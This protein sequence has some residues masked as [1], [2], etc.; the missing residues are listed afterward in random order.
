MIWKCIKIELNY[1]SLNLKI[2]YFCKHAR[3]YLQY[4]YRDDQELDK[5]THT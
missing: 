4:L 3:T 2:N 5:H 1:A